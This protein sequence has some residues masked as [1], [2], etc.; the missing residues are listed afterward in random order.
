M[1]TLSFAL[2]DG[3]TVLTCTDKTGPADKLAE[4]KLNEKSTKLSQPCDSLGRTALTTC[5]L[6]HSTI[7]YYAVKYSDQ[8][9]A[10]CVKSGGTWTTNKSLEAQTA[11]AE[12]DFAAA[13]AAAG[14]RD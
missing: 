10:D 5:D 6:G 13:K 11:R 7:K 1:A 4:L 12:Q 14:I 3:S 8:Y 2:F 9:M